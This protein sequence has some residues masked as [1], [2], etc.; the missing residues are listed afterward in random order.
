MN[1][2]GDFEYLGRIDTQIKINGYKVE[3]KEITKSISKFPN[4]V[5]SHI[6]VIEL[7]NSIKALAVYYI[8]SENKSFRV[9]ILFESEAS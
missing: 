1:E 5:D 6:I 9:E 4:I 7:E 3:V 8:A 2:D